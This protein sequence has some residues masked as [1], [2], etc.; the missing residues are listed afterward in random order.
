MPADAWFADVLPLVGLANHGRFDYSDCWSI[1]TW[2][3]QA[4]RAVAHLDSSEPAGKAQL[5]LLSWARRLPPPP[6][7]S[8]LLFARKRRRDDARGEPFRWPPSGR[9]ACGLIRLVST[10]K[11]S[12]GLDEDQIA[13]AIGD[14][15]LHEVHCDEATKEA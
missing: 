13:D 7:S 2:Y 6:T 5:E 3:R 15:D 11:R 14:G 12:G 4:R 8:R 10:G 1:S 9:A